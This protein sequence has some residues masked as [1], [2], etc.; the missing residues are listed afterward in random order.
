VLRGH[1]THPQLILTAPGIRRYAVWVSCWGDGAVT[2]QGGGEEGGKPPA[3][4]P[5]PRVRP[6]H[7]EVAFKAWIQ[8][9]RRF[10]AGGGLLQRRV[11]SQTMVWTPRGS[12]GA[13]NFA[14]AA[15]P[16]HIS[17]DCRN[18]VARPTARAPWR[19]RLQLDDKVRFFCYCTHKKKNP[20]RLMYARS[21]APGW[22][23]APPWAAGR[24]RRGPRP[25]PGHPGPGM[26]TYPVVQ[27]SHVGRGAC[28]GVGL[29]VP[30]GHVG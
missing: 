24:P 1:P 9:A 11:A 4:T 3:K 17:A 8:A 18:C 5:A 10:P 22:R 15:P 2:W 12:L 21:R 25:G 14:S 19:H 16:P 13:R 29:V 23:G 27:T 20:W 30:G 7:Q 28:P 6:T 26:R